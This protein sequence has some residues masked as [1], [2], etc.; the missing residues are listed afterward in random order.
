MPK[1]G[2]PHD[3]SCGGK[4]SDRNFGG[5]ICGESLNIGPIHS[6]VS[7]CGGK[8]CEGK[9]EGERERERERARERE[10]EKEIWFPVFTFP[11]VIKYVTAK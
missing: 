10:N 7:I 6:G 4:F 8:I 3:E 1:E 5:K 2:P 11:T 9:K